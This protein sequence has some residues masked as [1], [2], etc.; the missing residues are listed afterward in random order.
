M[1]NIPGRAGLFETIL[2]T[3]KAAKRRVRRSAQG[4]IIHYTATSPITLLGREGAA[5]GREIPAVF[6]AR[7]NHLAAALV[8]RQAAQ[9]KTPN[10]EDTEPAA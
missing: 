8:P 9:T 10:L 4:G 2:G 3:E 6:P 7:R 5:D 1:L